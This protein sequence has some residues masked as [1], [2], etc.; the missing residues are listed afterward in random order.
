MLILKST[1]LC[2]WNVSEKLPCVDTTGSD[3]TGQFLKR[4]KL[5]V[6]ESPPIGPSRLHA[7]LLGWFNQGCPSLRQPLS[8]DQLH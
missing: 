5:V 4:E 6:L 1:A 2:K 8:L 3:M 7:S